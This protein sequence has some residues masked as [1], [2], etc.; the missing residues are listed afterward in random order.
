M[1]QV[2]KGGRPPALEAGGEGGQVAVVAGT[3]HTECQL[4][5]WPRSNSFVYW[6]P[7]NT[8][9]RET[10]SS[11]PFYQQKQR[12]QRV[13]VGKGHTACIG[14]GLPSQ[15]TPVGEA[16]T[17]AIH[18]LPELEAEGQGQGSAGS[19]SSRPLLL[20]GGC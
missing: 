14:A 10:F 19:F 5:A 12:A 4:R 3:A 16:Y 20:A 1:L 11:P 17:T 2:R 15:S 18:V 13:Q 7:Q 9:M 8:L 6:K